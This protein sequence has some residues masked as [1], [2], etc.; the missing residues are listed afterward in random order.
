MTKPHAPQIPESEVRI[1]WYDNYYDGPLVGLCIVRGEKLWF[2]MEDEKHEKVYL[3][4]ELLDPDDDEPDF[5]V[6]RTRVF[7]LYRLTRE[8]LRDKEEK[9]DAFREHVGWHCDFSLDGKRYKSFHK[10]IDSEDCKE[11][12]AGVEASRQQF[13]IDKEEQIVGYFEEK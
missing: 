7:H 10:N 4:D 9:H 5:D 6:H 12:Y 13:K 2:E 1:L 11:Y 3:T 8:Q